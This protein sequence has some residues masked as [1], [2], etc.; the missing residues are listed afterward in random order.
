[1]CAAPISSAYADATKDVNVTYV[2]TAD[3]LKASP[4]PTPTGKSAPP[5]TGD[6]SHIG[7]FIAIGTGSLAA[8]GLMLVYLNKRKE[9]DTQN[10]EN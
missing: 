8:G 10:A 2:V 7:V 9:D 4:T 6:D 1:M 3:M 5:K